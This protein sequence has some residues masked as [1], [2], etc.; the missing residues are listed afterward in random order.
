VKSDFIR[1]VRKFFET[2]CL[3]PSAN[4]MAI[5]L[6]PKKDEPEVLK[7]FRP[8]SLCNVI[9]KVVSKCMVNMLRPVL[10]D[11]IGPMQSAFE[12]GR[13]ITDNALIAF[14]YLQAI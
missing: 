9:Y 4:E 8:I 11:V 6:I 14:E 1:G 7:D 3:P 12:P 10:Q 13:M 2:G 5:V